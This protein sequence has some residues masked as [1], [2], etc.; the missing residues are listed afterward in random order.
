MQE[1]EE[2]EDERIERIKVT[3]RAGRSPE[4]C[5]GAEKVKIRGDERKGGKQSRQREREGN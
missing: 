1:E 3:S 2:E 5:G 4:S